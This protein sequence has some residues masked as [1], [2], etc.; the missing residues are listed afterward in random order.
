MGPAGGVDGE[1]G[2][3]VVG[4]DDCGM[5]LFWL[6]PP[7]RVNARKSAAPAAVPVAASHLPLW[8]LLLL[9]GAAVDWAAAILKGAASIATLPR[10][11]AICIFHPKE[12]S[13]RVVILVLR[14]N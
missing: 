9:S 10:N 6:D 4:P 1:V 12:R 14:C 8:L 3:D 2:V 13:V 7:E 11:F 5:K